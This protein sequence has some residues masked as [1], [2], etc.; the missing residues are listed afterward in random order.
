MVKS[1]KVHPDG[2][3]FEGFRYVDTT[4]A[5]YI[6]ES[7]TLRYDPRDMA[8][9]RLFHQGQFLCRA[10]CPELAGETV[11]LR[12]VLRA[13]SQRRGQLRATLR[14]LKKVV[15]ALVDLKR[16]H[17]KA[18][19]ETGEKVPDTINRASM[20]NL[21]PEQTSNTTAPLRRYVNE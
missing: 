4:L 15:D 16:G 3:R 6:G 21:K 20:K 5:A 17:E 1:R 9:V 18:P 7:V 2:I 19:T 11:P 8:E 10:I 14:E 12:D 13:R